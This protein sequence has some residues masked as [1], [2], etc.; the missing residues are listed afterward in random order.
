MFYLNFMLFLIFMFFFSNLGA[1]P[2][3]ALINDLGISFGVLHFGRVT[4]SAQETEFWLAGESGGV[5]RIKSV[6]AV[7]NNVR[8]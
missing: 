7:V 4:I 1:F 6:N 3:G 8:A 2:K 5:Y